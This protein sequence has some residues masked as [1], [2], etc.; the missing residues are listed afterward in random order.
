M[1]GWEVVMLGRLSKCED[2]S[3]GKGEDRKME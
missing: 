1:S 2:S 3:W